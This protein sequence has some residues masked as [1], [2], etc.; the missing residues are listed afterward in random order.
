MFIGQVEK[1][2]GIEYI[3]EANKILGDIIDVYGPILENIEVLNYKGVL[4]GD[5]VIKKLQEYDV[6]VL[7][8]F[9][10]AEG[11]PGII[12]EAFSLSKPVISTNFR[13]IPEIVDHEINGVLIPPKNLEKLIKAIKFFNDNNYEKL[14]KNAYTKFI[15]CFECE[16]VHKIIFKYLKEL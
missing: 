6:L 10:E 4:F 11:Y 7:P 8:T 13:A 9:W 3:N 14:S 2:K 1:E 12:L 5:E 15:Q 16:K